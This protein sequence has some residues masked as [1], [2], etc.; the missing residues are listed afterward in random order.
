LID[1]TAAI[2]VAVTVLTLVFSNPTRDTMLVGGAAIVVLLLS[3]A[4]TRR[5]RAEELRGLTGS[6]EEMLDQSIARAEA[7]I[8]RTRFQLRAIAPSFALGLF[9]AAMADG[10]SDAFSAQLFLQPGLPLALAIGAILV[11]AALA[12]SLTRS[13]RSTRNERDQ[14]VTLRDAFK[15]E[16]R[17][18]EGYVSP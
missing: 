4:R 18:S 12:V 15:A 11:L 17:S 1:N 2:V 14:L 10:Q 7:T 13:L 9:F 5:L 16:N 8:K 3:Q 6:T